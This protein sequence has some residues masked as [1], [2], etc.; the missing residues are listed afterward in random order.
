MAHVLVLLFPWRGMCLDGGKLEKLDVEDAPLHDCG[1]CRDV[2]LDGVR[3]TAR[4]R[5]YDEPQYLYVP[6]T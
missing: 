2:Y 6:K 1:L 5:R 3:C 4:V